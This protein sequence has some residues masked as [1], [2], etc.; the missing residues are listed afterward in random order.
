LQSFIST[1]LVTSLTAPCNKIILQDVQS[2]PPVQLTV[3][4]AMKTRSWSSGFWHGKIL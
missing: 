3:F 2:D 4:T 1:L